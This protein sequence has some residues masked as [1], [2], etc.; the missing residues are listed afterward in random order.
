MIQKKDFNIGVILDMDGVIIDSNPYHKI[1]WT[2]FLNRKNIVVNDSIFKE[3]IF[4]TTSDEAITKLLNCEL[5]KRELEIFSNEIDSEYRTI[6]RKSKNIEP[7]NGLLPFLK[8]ISDE[9][10]KIAL[11]TSAPPEN[12]DLILN[13][14]QIL[15]YFDLI[16]DKT[17][18]LNSKPNP[19][20]YLKAVQGLGLSNDNCVVFEDSI[21]GIISAKDAGLIVIGVTT[22]HKNNELIDAGAT[23]CVKDFFEISLENIHKLIENTLRDRHS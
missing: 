2:N 19:E 3:L 17:Q 5:S 6:I 1:A 10:C 4:G 9:C 8:S 12:V 16:I 11:A 21:S 20:I 18:V 22:S 14:F 23:I 7:L 15:N 13:R